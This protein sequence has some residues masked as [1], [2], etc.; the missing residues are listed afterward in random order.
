MKESQKNK[1]EECDG[2]G[3]IP[4]TTGNLTLNIIC[5]ICK[6]NGCIIQSK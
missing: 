1:C 2:K 4:Y 5:P 6:G 3:K